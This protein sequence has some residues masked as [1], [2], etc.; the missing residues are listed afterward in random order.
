MNEGECTVTRYLE[1]V[2]AGPDEYDYLSR[3]HYR[4][5]ALGAHVAIYAMRDTHPVRARFVPVVGVIVYTMPAAHVELRNIAT[6]G[7]FCGFGDRRLQLQMVNKHIRRIARVVIEPRY[8]GLGLGRRLVAET[9]GKLDVPIIEA[10]AVMGAVHPFFERAGMK[11]Y[12]AKGAERSFRLVEALS[13]IGIKDCEFIDS[14]AV[15]DKLDGLSGAEAEFAERQIRDFLQTYGKRRQMAPG[16]ERTRYV[17]SRLTARPVYY[18]W[19]NPDK[20]Q[21]LN[22]RLGGRI[23]IA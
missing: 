16:I 23:Y 22:R 20:C 12:E 19:F 4:T 13:I 15:Q 17:L 6:G 2:R 1:I 11:R 18:I 3:F 14:K 7:L 9:M 8:R 21:K 5:E 10:M